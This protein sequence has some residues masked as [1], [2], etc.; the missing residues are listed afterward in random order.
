[1]AICM[2]QSLTDVMKS[3]HGMSL[4][5]VQQSTLMKS[6]LASIFS[7]AKLIH[8]T[9]L[10]STFLLRIC[11]SLIFSNKLFCHCY[12]FSKCTQPGFGDNARLGA[13]LGH[14]GVRLG[15]GRCTVTYQQGRSTA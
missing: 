7:Y 3:L 13:E 14:C 4:S 9:T 15:G 1:M 8:S 5:S 6:T 2:F 11:R 12:L 10:D